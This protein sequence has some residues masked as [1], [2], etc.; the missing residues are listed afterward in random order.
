MSASYHLN[1]NTIDDDDENISK[2]LL[3]NV[4]S[5][6]K[7]G[8]I[9]NDSLTCSELLL[10]KPD[11]H[12]ILYK[13]NNSLWSFLFFLLPSWLF[14]KWKKRY[15]ILIG[16]YLYKFKDEDDD[17]VRGSP[18]PLE[19]IQINMITDNNNN[20]NLTSDEL[21]Q[22]QE[23]CFEI[24]T[25]RKTYMFKSDSYDDVMK[26]I[27]IIKRRKFQ[28][29]KESM[30]HAPVSAEVKRINEI[31]MNLVKKKLR[32]DMLN[33]SNSSS[34]GVNSSDDVYAHNPYITSY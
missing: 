9:R 22:G 20:G 34:G 13:Y 11:Y 4:N 8:N 19:A 26:W 21:Q 7:N 30:G 24:V 1:D 5:S 27:N 3:V 32:L 15:F 6:N 18:I 28:S 31:G 10:L 2:S 16:N 25:L 14:E 33:S 12:G 23:H 29:I 17:R